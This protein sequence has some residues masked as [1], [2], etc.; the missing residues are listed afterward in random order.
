MNNNR[1][2]ALVFVLA[3]ASLPLNGQHHSIGPVLGATLNKITNQSDLTYLS[4]LTLGGMY[5]YSIHENYGVGAKVLYQQAGF[6]YKNN[7]NYTR[8]HYIQVPVNMFYYFGKLGES[9][10]PKIFG[11]IYAAFLTEAKEVTNDVKNSIKSYLNGT[12]FGGNLGAGLNIKAKEKIWL[13]LDL[14]YQIGFLDITK[15]TSTNHKN[16]GFNFQVGLTFPLD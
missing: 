8:M 4:G 16:T 12:D 1:F 6:G 13:N 15:N 14:A 7:D 9:V 2:F 11:G 5:N 3:C 10:R